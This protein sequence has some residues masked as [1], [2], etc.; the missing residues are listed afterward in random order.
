[1]RALALSG[2]ILLVVTGTAP[3]QGLDAGQRS[4]EPLCAYFDP[5]GLIAR[6]FDAIGLHPALPRIRMDHCGPDGKPIPQRTDAEMAKL[7]EQN[8]KPKGR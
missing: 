4:G 3:G 7:I 6:F 1:M 2:L 5:P 8:Y